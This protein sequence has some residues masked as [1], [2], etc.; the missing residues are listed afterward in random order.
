MVSTLTKLLGLGGLALAAYLLFFQKQGTNQEYAGAGSFGGQLQ[1]YIPQGV[2][3]ASKAVSDM[4]TGAGT[5]GFP[6]QYSGQGG[7]LSLY[8]A[9]KAREQAQKVTPT[10]AT[11]YYGASSVFPRTASGSFN[12]QSRY[13]APK[14]PTPAQVQSA[15]A[16]YFMS[17]GYQ[18]NTS[19]GVAQSLG[20]PVSFI[21]PNIGAQPASQ[22]SAALIN[23]LRR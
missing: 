10:K 5:I 13:V 17:G 14:A 22:T 8:Y 7:N 11:P 16:A 1:S 6:F 9:A 15:G 18:G 12:L 21:N 2:T 19:T 3:D 20:L 4:V 23:Y